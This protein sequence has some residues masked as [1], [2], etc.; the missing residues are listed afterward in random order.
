[1]RKHVYV[2]GDECCF[3]NNM[4]GLGWMKTEVPNIPGL[5]GLSPV[6]ISYSLNCDVIRA[7]PNYGATGF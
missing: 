1:M 5:S 2:L 3:P 6:T 4:P 7:Q